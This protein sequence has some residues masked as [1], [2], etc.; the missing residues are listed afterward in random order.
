[1]HSQHTSVVRL[2]VCQAMLIWETRVRVTKLNYIH[3]QVCL[4][5]TRVLKTTSS[6][7]MEALLGIPPIHVWVNGKAKRSA[8]TLLGTRQWRKTEFEGEHRKFLAAI[9]KSNTAWKAGDR[10]TVEHCSPR[11]Y[12]IWYRRRPRGLVFYTD[13]SKTE[14]GVNDGIY[15]NRLKAKVSLTLSKYQSIFYRE[16]YVITYC[17]QIKLEKRTLNK[18]NIYICR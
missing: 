14:T 2:M 7:A 1:M 11:W 6:A 15:R 4:A 18:Y 9:L 5:I 12:N 17:V 8:Y 10:G 16:V 13:G 3:R